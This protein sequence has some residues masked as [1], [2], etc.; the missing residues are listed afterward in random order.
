MNVPSRRAILRVSLLA[1]ALL[2]TSQLV[3]AQAAG[4]QPILLWPDGAPGA[5]GSDD[6]DKPSI[7]PFIATGADKV[8][9]AVIVCPGGSYSHLSMQ[10]EGTDVAK[11]LNE[12]GISAFVLKYRLGPKYHHPIEIGDAQ[13]AIRY[14]RLH[15]KEY[16]Y[17][18]NRIGIWGFSAGGHLAAT[19]GTHFDA[20]KS[21]SGDPIERQSSRPDFMILAYPVITFTEPFAH[22]GSRDAL[23][24]T[25]PDPALI[26]LLSNEK[27]VTKDTPPAFLFHTSEDKTVPVENSV[28]FYLAL[29]EAGV[30]AEMHIFQKGNHGVGLAPTD[31]ALSIWPDI[32]GA[33]LKV[34]GLR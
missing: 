4:P 20:G 13:R 10:K 28:M 21:D 8:P 9:T 12:R 26:E 27:H 22:K 19:A 5:L 34:Q 30:P 14:V 24:G 29:H 25:N 16:G 31:P 7:I 3:H 32:L 11:W 17:D 15:A 6:V 33:W 2:F 23:L 1:I 18:A